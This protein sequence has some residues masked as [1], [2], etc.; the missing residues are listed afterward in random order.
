MRD[1]MDWNECKQDF[2]KGVE[3]DPAKIAAIIKMVDSRIRFLKNAPLLPEQI[4]F[5]VEGYY[6]AIKELLTALLLSKGLRS[7]NHQCLITYF[8]KNYPH[9]EAEAYLIAE[10][11][12]LR[13]RLNYYGEQIPS[14]FYEKNKDRFDNIIEIIKKIIV[15]KN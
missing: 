4:S 6:E 12:Y 11:N 14:V 13:N 8:Y 15:N 2:I 7:K 3:K 9:Y 5:F 1:F 10:M